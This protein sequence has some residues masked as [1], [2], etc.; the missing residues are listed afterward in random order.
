MLRTF[1]GPETPVP[2]QGHRRTR[3]VAIVVGVLVVV[4]AVAVGGALVVGGAHERDAAVGGS[5]ACRSLV[6]D[7]RRYR[8]R[9]VPSAAFGTAGTPRRAVVSCDAAPR[10]VTVRRVAGVDPRVAVARP[11][12][13]DR[14]FVA[15]GVCSRARAN[16]LLVCLRAAPRTP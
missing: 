5:R 8:A 15:A 14:I 10:R 6:F 3:P 13:R 16:A 7:G 11:E 2:G 9:Q 12:L 4:S 1:E